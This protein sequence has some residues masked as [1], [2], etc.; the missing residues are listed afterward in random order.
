MGHRSAFSVDMMV[1]IQFYIVPVNQPDRSTAGRYPT[2]ATYIARP[3]FS[4]LAACM[5]A[6]P[7][8][9][10]DKDMH[11]WH[12]LSSARIEALLEDN[13]MH[14]HPYRLGGRAVLEP[15]KGA[16]KEAWRR[17][18]RESRAENPR[19][20]ANSRELRLTTPHPRYHRW[21]TYPRGLAAVWAELVPNCPV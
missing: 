17:D 1:D 19:D 8:P 2:R 5:L 16:G 6:A 14:L 9:K 11:K 18:P 10:R 7:L 20:G 15:N 4:P 3:T 12:Y 21:K 13:I